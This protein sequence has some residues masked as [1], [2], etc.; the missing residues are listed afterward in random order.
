MDEK[1]V[2]GQQVMED[3]ELDKTYKA[4]NVR[5]PFP[6][7]RN[8]LKPISPVS[9]S[10]PNYALGWRTGMNRVTRLLITLDHFGVTAM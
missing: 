9:F 3:S 6:S 10:M 1:N 8:Y 2:Y 4:K 5:T 7:S